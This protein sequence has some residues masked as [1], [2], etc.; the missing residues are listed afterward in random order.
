MFLKY[1]CDMSYCANH[2]Q[3]FLQTLLDKVCMYWRKRDKSHAHESLG[4]QWR[5]QEERLCQSRE[6]NNSITRGWE[7]GGGSFKEQQGEKGKCHR[8]KTA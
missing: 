2:N 4:E 3:V 5:V 1:A 7:G 8:F 6:K